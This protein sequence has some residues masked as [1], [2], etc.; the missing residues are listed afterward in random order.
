[1]SVMVCSDAKLAEYNFGEQHP[2]GPARFFAFYDEF[3]R[4]E[5]DRKVT[6]FN[7][8][9]ATQEQIEW[10]HAHKYVENVKL[11]SMLG[12]GYLDRG[13][14]PA[15]PG[16]FEAASRVVGTSL[17]AMQLIMQ[18]KCNR[19]FVPI[20]GLHH[21]RRDTAAGFCVFNDCGVVIEALRKLYNIKRVLYVDIDAHHGDGVYYSYIDD[22]DVIIIDVHE[23]GHF[24]YPGTGAVTETGTGKAQGSK[25]NLPMPMEADDVVFESLWP[26]IKSFITEFQFDFILLQCGADS[27][28]NDPITHMA[29]SPV[30]HAK[31]TQ[32]LCQIADNN[33]SGRL[34]VMG[35]G[36][37]NLENIAHGWNA[38]VNALVGY[39]SEK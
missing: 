7:S 27:I 35:G 31:V 14:T 19:A 25:L 16:V 36:G 33:C 28:K 39:T 10:F 17:H 9:L 24:L 4:Q 18:E 2:F 13:D 6:S 20:A 3:K 15:F 23:D 38:V 30:T 29:L 5:L 26:S 12:K 8:V 1:M 11:A 21:A 34:L 22:P 32:R 37:Y